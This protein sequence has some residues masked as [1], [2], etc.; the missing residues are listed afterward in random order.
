VSDGLGDGLSD[1]LAEGLGDGVSDGLGDGLG[2][3][4]G[5][6]C[7]S[8]QVASPKFAIKDAVPVPSALITQMSWFP[9]RLEVN[10][11]LVL[12]GDQLG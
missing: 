2:D 4:S 11:S 8:G 7:Q 5:M 3:G 12:S 10:S 9:E 1:G 6:A